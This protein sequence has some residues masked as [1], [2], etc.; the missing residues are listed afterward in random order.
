MKYA[1]LPLLLCI[2]LPAHAF[3]LIYFRDPSFIVWAFVEVP[4]ILTTA[5]SLLMTLLFRLKISQ[6]PGVAKVFF[7][8]FKGQF[9]AV[10]AS[11]MIAMIAGIL[12]YGLLSRDPHPLV[13]IVTGLYFGA[14]F[15]W[16]AWW[17]GCVGYCKLLDLPV[18]PAHPPHR[19]ILLAL[20]TLAYGLAYAHMLSVLGR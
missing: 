13:L 17:L 3:N 16:L 15:I 10:Y 2:S 12:G 14:A 4:L 5:L 9:L 1:A 7:T 6:S 18:H 11:W 8:G 20:V 19:W